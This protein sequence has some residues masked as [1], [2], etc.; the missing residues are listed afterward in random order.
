M[1][2]TNPTIL[3]VPGSFS[4][5]TQYA[6]L[7]THLRAAGF[8]AFAIQL[9]STQKR[10]PLPPATMS[11]D[12]SLIKRTAEMLI[13]QGKEVVVLAHSYGGTPT[14]E[15]LAGL[16]V[17]RIVYLSAIVP[18]VGETNVVAMGGEEG[19]LPLGLEDVVR[20]YPLFPPLI[21]EWSGVEM[22]T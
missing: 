22:A 20:L 19:G 9:P 13:S 4:P 2:P 16:K 17:S 10:M 14:S 3:V 21:F 8:P 11:D 7:I 15:G 6:S 5:S 18:A 1:S 12:A